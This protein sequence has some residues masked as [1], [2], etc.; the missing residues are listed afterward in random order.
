MEKSNERGSLG[1]Q[2]AEEYLLKKGY[3][4]LD[5][6]YKRF[7]G[8]IDLIFTKGDLLVFVEVKA[9]KNADFGYP[10]DFVTE[11][12]QRKIISAAE[13]YINENEL[14]DYQ[15][16]FDVIEIF[17]EEPIRIEHIEDAFP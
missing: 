11:E 14:Y 10:S 4:F 1:E 3:T 13:I 2:L 15:P 8:E 9:R 12:K 6:N 17:L 7:T 16:I 5:R